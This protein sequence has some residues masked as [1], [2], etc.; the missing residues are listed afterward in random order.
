MLKVKKIDHI[1]LIT[2]LIT[3]VSRI[4][5]LYAGIIPRVKITTG[6]TNLVMF[7]N[8]ILTVLINFSSVSILYYIIILIY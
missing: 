1:I 6:F 3:N 4:I 2:I 7:S 8:L 5:I